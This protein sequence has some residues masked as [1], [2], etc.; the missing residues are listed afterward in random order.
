MVGSTGS[1]LCAHCEEQVDVR[2]EVE[3][4]VAPP[5]KLHFPSPDAFADW[6]RASN[7][8]LSEFQR[9]S[10]YNWHRDEL[11]PLVDALREQQTSSH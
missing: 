11:E 5:L 3:A 4:T 7:F 8:T 2:I 10:L 1:V 6:L 9:L